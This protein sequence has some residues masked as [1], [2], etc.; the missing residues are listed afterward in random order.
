MISISIVEDKFGTIRGF[1]IQGH[2]GYAESG[3]DIVCAAVSALAY[4]AV[5]AIS[6]MHKEPLWK[7]EDGYM[8]CIVPD[9][10]VG[11]SRRVVNTIM[12]TIIIGF[13]QIELS[14]SEYV[15]IDEKILES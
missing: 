12:N 11:D 6:D 1:E 14:Y 5:G 13:K 2:S 15:R 8:K 9:E 10:L 7:S 4:T 3:K